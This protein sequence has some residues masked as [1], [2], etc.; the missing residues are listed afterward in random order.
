M[1]SI[2]FHSKWEK[3]FDKLSSDIQKRIWK[4][5]EQIEQ[6]LPGRHLRHGASYFIEEVGQYRIAYKSLEDKKI[7]RFY[8]VG[9]HKD[10]EKWFRKMK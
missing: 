6:G 7:R 3:Y 4:K 2:E 9:N 1:Y 8:F 5:I 10:Y